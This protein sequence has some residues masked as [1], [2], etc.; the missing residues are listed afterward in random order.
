MD[1]VAIGDST[2]RAQRLEKREINNHFY[3]FPGEMNGRIVYFIFLRN[4]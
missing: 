4:K 2:K 1:G 3:L